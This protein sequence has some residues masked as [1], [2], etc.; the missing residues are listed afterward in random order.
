MVVAL[1]LAVI[2]L[3]AEPIPEGQAVLVRRTVLKSEDGKHA[4]Q[5]ATFGFALSGPDSGLLTSVMGSDPYWDHFRGRQPHLWVGKEHYPG[6]PRIVTRSPLAVLVGKNRG[7]P[8]YGWTSTFVLPAD[9][10]LAGGELA[11]KWSGAGLPRGVPP[12][13]FATAT[14]TDEDVKAAAAPFRATVLATGTTEE[15]YAR[16]PRQLPY[17]IFRTDHVPSFTEVRVGDDKPVAI[18][19]SASK[20]EG[21]GYHHRQQDGQILVLEAA[22]KPGA[23]VRMK[24]PGGDGWYRTE[25]AEGSTP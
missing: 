5:L 14:L 6:G 21:K 19:R 4:V 23:A 25:T 17:L 13:A 8:P 2:T 24:F 11:F 10:K 18:G 16:K 12:A 1:L 22:P 9:A 15:P 20:G 7:L 3:P